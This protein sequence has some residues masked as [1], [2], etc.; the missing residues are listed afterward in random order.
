MTTKHFF[1]LATLVTFLV[2]HAAIA[3]VDVR[4]RIKN[5]A[6]KIIEN[7]ADSQA[8]DIELQSALQQL[9]DINLTI[10]S[11]NGGGGSAKIFCEPTGS[12]WS[13]VVRISDGFR[14]GG[15]VLNDQC[16][17]I[18][19]ASKN[20]LV[21]GPTSTSWARIRNIATG[22]LIGEEVL[23]DNCIDLI[24]SSNRQL[25]CGPSSMSWAYLI[26]INDGFKLSAES[27]HSQCKSAIESS[28]PQLVCAP[29]STS[30][31]YIKRI[32]TGEK[33]GQELLLD[34]CFQRLR[35]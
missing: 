2:S 9:R 33:I 12:A 10:G 29:T 32:A 1:N 11:S 23:T 17:R 15:E 5:Q 4:D 31:A 20:G 8:T 35:Q 16:Q 19:A 7:I 25:V 6:T 18:V 26:R 3:Q 13:Y 28:T 22:A 30:W 34:D 14:F 27:L 21:C 24:A